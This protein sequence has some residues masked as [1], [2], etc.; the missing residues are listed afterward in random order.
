MKQNRC[1][2]VTAILDM[3]PIVKNLACKNF[4]VLFVLA[5]IK[6]LMSKV[7]LS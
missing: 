7:F 4:I 3:V 1:I 6:T 5:M 2:E